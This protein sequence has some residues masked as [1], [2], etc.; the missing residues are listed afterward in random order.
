MKVIVY[1]VIVGKH[2][3]WRADRWDNFG[4]L[5]ADGTLQLSKRS[6]VMEVKQEGD[7][8]ETEHL[9]EYPP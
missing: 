8:V 7:T 3:M 2:T 9:A 4:Q 6:A 1:P 5:L